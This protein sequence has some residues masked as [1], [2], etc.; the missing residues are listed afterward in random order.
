MPGLWIRFSADACY[1]DAGGSAEPS[2]SQARML[3]GRC[4]DDVLPV[5]LAAKVRGGIRTALQTGVARADYTLERAGRLCTFEVAFVAT[6]PREVAAFIVDVTDRVTAEQARADSER[7][8]RSV[9]EIA[10]EGVWMIDAQGLTTFVTWRMAAILGCTPADVLGRPP[11][12]FMDE[13]ARLE[14][15]RRQRKRRRGA[16]GAGEFTLR[17]INGQMVQTMLAASPILDDQ[18]RYVGSVALVTDETQRLAAERELIESRQRLGA[19]AQATDHVYYVGE[20]VSDDTYVEHFCSP[21]SDRLLGGEPPIGEPI[22]ESWARAIHGADRAAYARMNRTLASGQPAE[23][24]YRLIGRDGQTRWV[25]DRAQPRSDAGAPGRVILDGVVCDITTRRKEAGILESAR[26]DLRSAQ[27]DLAAAQATNDRL[28]RAE[29]LTGLLHRSRIAQKLGLEL[30]TGGSVGVILIDIDKFNQ[31][32]ISR[33]YE[34]GDEVL[35]QAANRLDACIPEHALGRWDGDGFLAV[36]SGI[37]QASELRRIAD[38]LADSLRRE[39]ISTS[40]G[41]VAITASA[42]AAFGAPASPYARPV[43]ELG[44][45]HPS[46]RPQANARAN[47]FQTCFMGDTVLRESPSGAISIS[48]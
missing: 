17:A 26:A 16:A 5:E 12:D 24:E 11:T 29:P 8:F 20:I 44:E 48:T 42:G 40:G 28:A 1:V 9:V 4:V 10:D 47:H 2:V 45:S 33:G 19:I 18:G 41:F 6:S 13:D 43:P 37:S 36:L 35:I 32:N 7:R 22:G 15:A 27:A 14:F 34:S 23:L 31:I 25:H 3:I 21:G 46:A 30:A 39:P 38:M